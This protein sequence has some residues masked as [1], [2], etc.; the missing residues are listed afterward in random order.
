[1]KP[2]L[3]PRLHDSQAEG[4][5]RSL[6]GVAPAVAS[7][8]RPAVSAALL[9]LAWP[10]DVPTRRAEAVT[11]SLRVTSQRIAR[12]STAAGV[13]VSPEFVVTSG[14]ATLVMGRFGY[15]F[16][17]SGSGRVDSIAGM[18]YEGDGPVRV[19]R[20]LPVANAMTVGVAPH[21]RGGWSVLLRSAIG[22][23]VDSSGVPIVFR[24]ATLVVARLA[25]GV[26]SEIV[27]LQNATSVPVHASQAY[28]VGWR[29]RTLR[30]AFV[31]AS[32]SRAGANGGVRGIV[33]HSLVGAVHSVDTIRTPLA[34][35]D[36]QLD[37]S[38]ATPAI[39][40][41]TPPGATQVRAPIWYVQNEA[42]DWVGVAG[43]GVTSV[44]RGRVSGP[45]TE[46]ASVFMFRGDD[47]LRMR[48]SDI[49]VNKS[50]AAFLLAGVT[51]FEA[52]P[53]DRRL[54]VAASV[55]EQPNAIVIGIASRTAESVMWTRISTM[56][57][58]GEFRLAV[59]GAHAIRLVSIVTTGLDGPAPAALALTQLGL[60]CDDSSREA[61]RGS[62]PSPE[63]AS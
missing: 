6:R 44:R 19:L 37:P 21:P 3:T 28:D 54:I 62:N 40:S 41:V 26:W 46:V 33:M 39:L 1:M 61:V 10:S 50:E 12:D 13:F 15:R 59:G 36:L 25:D 52:E 31:V 60:R 45:T 42:S 14:N 27:E 16:P 18:W 20:R 35:L 8:L 11:C 22:S 24:R 48:V 58:G 34:P 9:A 2:R 49:E 51:A 7:L 30:A 29:G 23:D 55:R 56:L 43:N 47:S 32:D 57:D 4:S 53:L 38:R 63:S 5:P 17:T